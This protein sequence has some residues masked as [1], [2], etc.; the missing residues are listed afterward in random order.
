MICAMMN[1]H[2]VVRI[3]LACL[4]LDLIGAPCVLIR[5]PV[6]LQPVPLHVFERKTGSACLNLKSGFGTWGNAGVSI[7][8]QSVEGC[9]AGVLCTELHR[10]HR[11]AQNA[12]NCTEC[13]E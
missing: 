5:D 7:I 12:Q 6:V 10:M 3:R 2:P 4:L 9:I 13:T 8:I 11:I 1:T